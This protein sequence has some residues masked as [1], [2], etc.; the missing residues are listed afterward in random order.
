MSKY[1]VQQYLSV[2][3]EFLDNLERSFSAV[4][5]LEN[6]CQT[7][8]HGPVFTDCRTFDSTNK[9]VTSASK[10]VCLHYDNVFVRY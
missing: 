8:I 5:A 3:F 4:G 6:S 2:V 1:A 7:V 9:I 10:F